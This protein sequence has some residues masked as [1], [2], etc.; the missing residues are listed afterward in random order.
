LSGIAGFVLS[1]GMAV[2]ANVLIFERLKE[3]LTWGKPLGTASEEGFKRAWPSIRDGNLT[4]LL[5]C[6]FLY[7][8][9][10]SIIKGFAL[11]LFIGVVFSMLSAITI[12][13]T[14]MNVIVGWPFVQRAK[15]LFLY[16]KSKEE[17]EIMT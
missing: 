7:W 4:T 10:T 14:F 12:T 16:K 17:Q 2:D 1:V 9:G 8:F 6:F 3:E 13:R 5:S 11:T 15:W